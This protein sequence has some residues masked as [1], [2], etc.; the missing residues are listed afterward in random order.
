MMCVRNNT[1][2]FGGAVKVC[3]CVFVC[4]DDIT[5]WGWVG[6]GMRMLRGLGRE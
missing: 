3:V 1:L 4:L 2:H 6:L 5:F